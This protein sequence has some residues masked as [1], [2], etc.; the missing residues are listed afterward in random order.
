MPGITRRSGLLLGGAALLTAAA[1]APD[2]PWAEWDVAVIG[3]GVTG[4]SAARN[5]T[6]HGLRVIVLEARDRIGGQVHTDHGFTSVPV[7]LGAGLIHGA[8]ASTWELVDWAG[9]DTVRVRSEQHWSPST[10]V[11]RAAAP[12]DDDSAAEYLRRLGVPEADWPP[13]SSEN[14]PLSRW[15]ATWMVERGEFDWW[16]APRADF[17]VVDGYDRL[18][19][20]LAHGLRIDLGRRV[21]A[22]RWSGGGVELTMRGPGGTER[23]RAR[24]CVATLPIRV[25]RTADVVFEPPLPAA[26]RDAIEA[27]DATDAV[28]LVMEFDRPVLPADTDVLP[29]DGDLAFWSVSHLSP[30][31]PEVVSVWAAGEAARALLAQP[32]DERFAAG[33]RALGAAA[34]QTPPDPVRRTTHDWTLDPHSR[35]AYLYVP[36]GAHDAPA[37]L[38]APVGGVLF[39]AGEATTGE[40]TVE[41][42]Y[43]S[44]YDATDGL[45]ADL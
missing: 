19:A 35:G 15:S 18:L 41:G 13:V 27:L 9:A 25:L 5:L 42:A 6:D 7:E 26:H 8:A 29:S 33:L 12:R 32:E 21:R 39:F 20:P 3:A 38:A 37:A 22:V 1:G 11:G 23:V 36:P 45:L 30:T 40:N 10:A 4:L 2:R 28:K 34:G 17:R 14:E 24:R 31:A 43:D 16:S 44:G